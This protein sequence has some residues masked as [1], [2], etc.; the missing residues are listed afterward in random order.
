MSGTGKLFIIF[1]VFLVGLYL[2][3]VCHGHNV[4][5]AHSSLH[6][7]FLIHDEESDHGD[8]KIVQ[9]EADN[10]A[11]DI[12]QNSSD[13]HDVLTV[14]RSES[15]QFSEKISGWG[16]S[17]SIPIPAPDPTS[18]PEPQSQDTLLCSVGP[19]SAAEGSFFVVGAVYAVWLDH[20]AMQTVFVAQNPLSELRDQMSLCPEERPPR[21]A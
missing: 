3:S 14:H 18:I 4:N 21:V 10:V 6:L 7:A 11:P 20:Y 1:L 9:G 19:S 17:A 15:V 2:T 16:Y 12:Q 5:G 8:E 13:E